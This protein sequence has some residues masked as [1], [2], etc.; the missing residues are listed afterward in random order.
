MLVRVKS[1]MRM[2]LMNSR[3]RQFFQKKKCGTTFLIILDDSDPKLL[4]GETKK[5]TR[6]KISIFFFNLF[7]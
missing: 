2:A 5:R 6:I 4:K 3:C 1:S 7:Q